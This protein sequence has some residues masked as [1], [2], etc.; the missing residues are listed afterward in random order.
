MI[1]SRLFAHEDDPDIDAPLSAPQG[2]TLGSSGPG[3]YPRTYQ[4]CYN[5]EHI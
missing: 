5:C 3:I 4:V 2:H 1:F